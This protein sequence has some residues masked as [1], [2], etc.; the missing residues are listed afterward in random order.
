MSSRH[1]R[2]SSTMMSSIDENASTISTS[3][4][5]TDD[6][7]QNDYENENDY[8][9][10]YSSVDEED[11]LETHR[12]IHHDSDTI[13][14]LGPMTTTTAAKGVTVIPASH[15]LPSLHS[16][17]EECAEALGVARECAMV[18]LRANKF[19]KQRT[20]EQYCNSSHELL[21]RAG[22]LHRIGY[23]MEPTWAKDEDEDEE[24]STV[25]VLVPVISDEECLI[26]MEP[27]QASN[28]NS[29]T[30]SCQ[31]TFCLDCWSD[32]LHNL[33][34]SNGPSCVDATCPQQ[35]C[36]ECITEV[37][38]QAAAPELLAKFQHYQLMSFVET[39]TLLKWCPGK[40]C[41][42][43]AKAASLHSL[44]EAP[45]VHCN[46]CDTSFCMVCR[47]EPHS[48][49]DC[50][51][52]LQWKDKNTNESETSNWIL[53][54]TKNCP[55]C[56]TRI[57]KDGGCQFVMC[58]S[59]HTGFCWKCMGTHHVWQCNAFVPNEQ[60]DTDE[61]RARNE[62]ERYLHYY[63]RYHLHDR[64]QKFAQKQLARLCKQEID[65][66]SSCPLWSK[67]KKC[68]TITTTATATATSCSS[69]TTLSQPN[70]TI[71]DLA[72]AP[73]IQIQETV[74]GPNKDVHSDVRLLGV[75][76]DAN[77]R[78]VECRRVLKF[79]YVFAYIH[80]VPTTT[81]TSTSEEDDGTASTIM[82]MS[83]ELK[84]QKECF[85]HHQGILEGLTEGL[86]KLTESR[87]ETMELQDVTNRTRV[88]GQFIKNVLEFVE[89]GMSIDL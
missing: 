42:Q 21:S 30:M 15:L 66:T 25:H 78:L 14:V 12:A 62:L 48:P 16:L 47:E 86:S 17:V 41:D 33:F 81:T 38:I 10:E 27:L 37:E 68:T 57:Q 49:C 31:H 7:S 4:T 20:V 58:Q 23:L 2:Q 22:V 59:C 64:A 45:A 35:N 67:S 70:D 73:M 71:K 51:Y 39:S 80:F 89:D 28:S 19:D 34:Q 50:Q 55:K 9:Y 32:Y 72:A 18:L 83:D 46:N 60:A 26:C 8:E 85:E 11:Y 1:I 52:L 5:M 24:I 74:S 29:L 40:G 13:Q 53:V 76:K 84:R 77:Q 61:A 44:E 54:N 75:L 88:I 56:A 36:K 63:E 87:R 3:I 79:S 69:T 6:E 82:V 65:S 43:V